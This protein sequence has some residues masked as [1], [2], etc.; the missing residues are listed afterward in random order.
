MPTLLLAVFTLVGCDDVKMTAPGC[1][2]PKPGWLRP[3]A[4]LE[5]HGIRNHVALGPDGISWNGE[6]V[7]CGQLLRYLEISHSIN[8]EPQVL[9]DVRPGVDCALVEAVRNEMQSASGCAPGKC[10]EGPGP[11]SYAPHLPSP[12]D[13]P[14]DL[15]VEADRLHNEA[16]KAEK[17]W[18]RRNSR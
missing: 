8:P 7:G 10:G 6:P 18:R 5:E 16:E 9:L 1:R 3:G 2:P 15:E 12:E 4:V 11:W 14:G 17:D 13:P